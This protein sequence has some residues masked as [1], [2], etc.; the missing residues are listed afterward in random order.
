MAMSEADMLQAQIALDYARHELDKERHAL[1]VARFEHQRKLDLS[2]L[3]LAV[4][5]PHTA[6]TGAPAHRGSLGEAS[7]ECGDDASYNT[8]T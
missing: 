4:R 6:A 5:E 7:P 2:Y 8:P 3:E 1:D